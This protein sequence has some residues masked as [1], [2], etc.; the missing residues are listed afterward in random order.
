MKTSID[1]KP[2]WTLTAAD[3]CDRCEALALVE[4]ALPQG[5]SLLWCAYHF[6]LFEDALNAVGATILVDER[7]R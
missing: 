2:L 7:R 1:K 6:D 4:T 5:G 3:R